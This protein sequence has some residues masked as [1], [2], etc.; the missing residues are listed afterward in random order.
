MAPLALQ[1]FHPPTME[2]LGCGLRLFLGLR[3][4]ALLER[5]LLTGNW[6]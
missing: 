4:G 3:L 1:Y 2:K 6:S 5:R